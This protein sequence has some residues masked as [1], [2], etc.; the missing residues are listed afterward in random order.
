MSEK[1][2]STNLIKIDASGKIFGRLA[3]EVA[4]LLRGKDL[5]F[6]RP[7]IVV[8]RTIN[9]FNIRKIKFSGKKIDKKTYHYH[10]GYLGGL[11]TVF[12]KNLFEKNPEKAF[13]KAVSGM[14]PKNKLRRKMIKN[15]KVS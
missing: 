10:T 14:L 6:F 7:N 4:A 13:I 3:S 2:E 9:V 12:L 15:L 11:K 5:P 1:I 8:K